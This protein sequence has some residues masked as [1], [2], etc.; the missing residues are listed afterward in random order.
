[1]V[2]A[3]KPVMLL[4]KLPKP[5]PLEVLV[6]NAIVGLAVVLQHTPLAVIAVPPSMVMF[7]PNVA[8]VVVMPDAV[9]VV[10]IGVVSLTQRTESP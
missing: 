5:V 2:F 6:V 4:V 3:V 10:R 7:P 1:V 9:V 8:V